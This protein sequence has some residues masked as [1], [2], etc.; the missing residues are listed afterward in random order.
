[1]VTHVLNTH[2]HFDPSHNNCLFA[3]AK[4]VCARKEYDWMTELCNRLTGEQMSLEGLYRYYP[5]LQ[6]FQDDPKIVWSMVRMVQRFWS[7]DRLGKRAQFEWLEDWPMPDG[8]R[9]IA[10]PGHVPFHYSF[11]FNTAEGPVLVAGDAMITRSEADQNVM[12]FPPTHR[13]M[14]EETKKKLVEYGDVIVPGHDLRF[15]VKDTPPENG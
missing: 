8:V 4:I 10:T 9:A 1:D 2:L 12:T 14:Y 3:G 6:M 13:V 11:V 5:E 7:A 15:C